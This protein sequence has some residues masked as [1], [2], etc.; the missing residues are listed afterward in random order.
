MRFTM[1]CLVQTHL[2][3]YAAD[4]HSP[5][6]SM[7]VMFSIADCRLA[8]EVSNCMNVYCPSGAP[9]IRVVRFDKINLRESK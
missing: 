4:F 6:S 1:L 8:N 2:M 7:K 5:F 3:K 9:G